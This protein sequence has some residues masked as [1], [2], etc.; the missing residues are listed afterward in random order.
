MEENEVQEE[1]KVFINE[2]SL[3]GI[4]NA[5]RTKSSSQDTFYPSEMPQAILDIPTEGIDTSD[6]NAVDTDLAQLKTAYVKGVKITGALPVVFSGNKLN[7]TNNI[8]VVDNVSTSKLTITA[9][10]T[11]SKKFSQDAIAQIQVNYSDVVA[12][13]GL[14]ADIIKEGETVLG[15]LGTYNPNA[16]QVTPA[17]NNDPDPNDEEYDGVDEPSGDPVVPPPSGNDDNPDPQECFGNNEPS[18]DDIIGGHNE[19]DPDEPEI[20]I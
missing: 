8:N 13:I 1:T 18:G 15:V 11:S 10:N 17:D 14:T 16:P 3:T 4:A 19:P 7:L 12:A 20:E 2:S 6:A 9:V 5:I